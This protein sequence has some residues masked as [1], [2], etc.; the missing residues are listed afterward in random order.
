MD[1]SWLDQELEELDQAERFIQET[2]SNFVPAT[3]KVSATVLPATAPKPVKTATATASS[4]VTSS[5]P[6]AE[7]EVDKLTNQLIVG[8]SNGDSK[9][10]NDQYQEYNLPPPP[11]LDD[12][13]VAQPPPPKPVVNGS[14]KSPVVKHSE[15]FPKPPTPTYIQEQPA[16]PPVVMSKPAPPPVLPKPSRSAPLKATHTGVNSVSFQINKPSSKPPSTERPA[17]GP[18]SE[19]KEAKKKA[20]DELDYITKTLLDNLDNPSDKDMYGFCAKCNKIVEGE[21]VGCTAMDQVYHIECFTCTSCSNPLHGEQ[22]FAIGNKPWCQP[23]YVQS[24]DKC[25]VCQAPI[26]ERILRAT[27]KAYHPACFTCMAC[28]K[29]L[30]GIPF[31]VDDNKDIYCVEDYHKKYAPRCSVCDDLIMPEPGKE[32]TVRIVA[33]DRSFHVHCYKCELCSVRLT[34]EKDGNGCFPLD[35]RILCKDCN[36]RLVQRLSA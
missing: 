5:M 9:K 10:T 32:E 15:D 17:V 11:D 27:G 29:S 3:S 4:Q 8:L 1:T 34:S 20:E 25:A 36:V 33:L 24:L 35:N 18:G 16:P 19:S 13:L 22:F 21:K 30:D 2:M 26:T 23:C 12:F 6:K 14:A 28:G 31:T 7:S